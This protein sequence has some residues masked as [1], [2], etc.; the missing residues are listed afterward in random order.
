MKNLSLVISLLILAHCGPNERKCKIS[1]TE[2]LGVIDCKFYYSLSDKNLD[3]CWFTICDVFIDSLESPAEIEFKNFDYKSF[4]DNSSNEDCSKLQIDNIFREASDRFRI[5]EKDS[6]FFNVDGDILNNYHF[7]MK[8]D[9][10]G[11][12]GGLIFSKPRIGI[13]DE[14]EF[15]LIRLSRYFE[16]PYSYK[17]FL[18]AVDS[19][20]SFKE[21]IVKRKD[22][23]LY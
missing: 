17:Y 4:Y 9:S 3:Q 19:N 10:I 8:S 23:K 2:L 18:I 20:N 13:I 12:K 6:F 14:E 21:L 7:R 15:V 5:I 22:M 1:L 11:Y 16:H